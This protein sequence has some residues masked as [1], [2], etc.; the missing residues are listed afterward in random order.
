MAT[1]FVMSAR[2]AS[3]LGVAGATLA[4]LALAG[5][6]YAFSLPY[7]LS[8]PRMALLEVAELEQ[9]AGSLIG[10]I[11]GTAALWGDSRSRRFGFIAIVLAVTALFLA[12]FTLQPHSTSRW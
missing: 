2:I 4:I 8:P 1:T 10:I 9:F 11:L 3:W 7:R 5:W 6:G 12:T